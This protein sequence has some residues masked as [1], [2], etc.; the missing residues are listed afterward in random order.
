DHEERRYADRDAAGLHDCRRT[1]AERRKGLRIASPAGDEGVSV[2]QEEDRTNGRDGDVDFAP[3]GRRPQNVATA[4]AIQVE[5]PN[6]ETTESAMSPPRT[7]NS[8][9]AKLMT[10]VARSVRWIPS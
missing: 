7:L 6:S 3:A 1:T 5:T 10:R 2:E 4:S 8:P 9:C